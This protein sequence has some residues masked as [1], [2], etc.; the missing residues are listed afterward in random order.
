MASCV[1]PYSNGRNYPADLF[2][3]TFPTHVRSAYMTGAEATIKVANG[4]C[5]LLAPT[6]VQGQGATMNGDLSNTARQVDGELSNIGGNSFS[7]DSFAW[8]ERGAGTVLTV[9]INMLLCQS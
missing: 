3:S 8:I 7:I 1:A 5:I 2:Y 6:R 9:D 4:E